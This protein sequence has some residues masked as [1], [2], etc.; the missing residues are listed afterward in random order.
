MTNGAKEGKP[1]NVDEA[2]CIVIQA[3]KI[4]L[5]RIRCISFDMDT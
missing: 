5:G 4:I 2:E 1:I 3:T